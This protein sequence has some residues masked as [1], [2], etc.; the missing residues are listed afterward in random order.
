[1]ADQEAASNA[2]QA[3]RSRRGAASSYKETDEYDVLNDK[4]GIF[5]LSGVYRAGHICPFNQKL[6]N[7]NTITFANQILTVCLTED[8]L[9]VGRVVEANPND[10][11]N[12]TIYWHGITEYR[13]AGFKQVDFFVKDR[14]IYFVIAKSGIGKWSSSPLPFAPDSCFSKLAFSSRHATA[15][16]GSDHHEINQARTANDQL[17]PVYDHRLAAENMEGKPEELVAFEGWSH[18]ESGSR[19]HRTA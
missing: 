5:R 15:P 18:L 10:F 6:I 19:E 14:Q 4:A 2:T 13:D 12:S 16:A 11:Y 1:M 8:R 3:K 9:V 17:E 7:F